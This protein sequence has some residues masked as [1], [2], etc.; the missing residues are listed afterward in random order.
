MEECGVTYRQHYS[1]ISLLIIL[2]IVHALRAIAS[3][4]VTESSGSETIT[5]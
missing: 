1:L 4:G 5:V 2:L 3:A